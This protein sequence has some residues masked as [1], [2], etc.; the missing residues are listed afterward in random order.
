MSICFPVNN[1]AGAS[2]PPAMTASGRGL[3]PPHNQL[4]KA[5]VLCSRHQ[6]GV[7]CSRPP[8]MLRLSLPRTNDHRRFCSVA[9]A[10]RALI[11]TGNLASVLT[12]ASAFAPGKCVGFARC[13]RRTRFRLLARSASW[14]QSSP[15]ISLS[16]C[17]LAARPGALGA[18][19]MTG[20]L[21]PVSTNA[22]PLTRG[23][24]ES[25]CDACSFGFA[26]RP[27]ALESRRQSSPRPVARAATASAPLP[28]E[29]RP[30]GGGSLR[31]PASTSKL[32]VNAITSK[33]QV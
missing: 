26:A 28:G 4:Y 21:A 13:G 27:G 29:S 12:N 6:A 15:A 32:P 18:L 24:K 17:R 10:S 5:G 2:F 9:A 33:E 11:D 1:N 16:R 25:D 8:H 20:D 30:R 31:R 23:A 3:L 19:S 14:R 7:L 22:A